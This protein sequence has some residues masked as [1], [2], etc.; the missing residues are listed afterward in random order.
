[1]ERKLEN[2]LPVT[3]EHD[4]IL[5]ANGDITTVFQ[6]V[7]PEGLTR[8]NEEYE[9]LN[10]GRIKAIK[11]LPNHVVYLQQDVF[12]KKV[13]QQSVVTESGE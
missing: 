11:S 10:Q 4:C 9:A 8:S 5:S 12:R 2:S 1:M 7:Y 13:F 6:A 3:V